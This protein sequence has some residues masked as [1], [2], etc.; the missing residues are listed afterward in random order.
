MTTDEIID[1]KNLIIGK[2][3]VNGETIYGCNLNTG[4]YIVGVGCI[5]YDHEM[6]VCM[7]AN[8]YNKQVKINHLNQWMNTNLGYFEDFGGKVEDK[9]VNMHIIDLA[10]GEL[11]EESAM[12]FNLHYEDLVNCNTVL[13]DVPGYKDTIRKYLCFI[14]HVDLKDHCAIKD[15]FNKNVQTMLSGRFSCQKQFLEI[16]NIK[17]FMVSDLERLIAAKKA[18][19]GFYGKPDYV[20]FAND[21]CGSPSYISSRIVN[22]VEMFKK[23][24]Q[25]THKPTYFTYHI[26]GL[27]HIVSEE[28]KIETAKQEQD[29]KLRLY[30]QKYFVSRL[31]STKPGVK[32]YIGGDIP[33]MYYNEINSPPTC[34][35]T[36]P[37]LIIYTDNPCF[38]LVDNIDMFYGGNDKTD[39]TLKKLFQTTSKST[40][41]Q[42]V[43][44]QLNSRIYFSYTKNSTYNR[45]F[46]GNI[47]AIDDT[48]ITFNN[49]IY[50]Q[51]LAVDSCNSI[52]IAAMHNLVTILDTTKV[53]FDYFDDDIIATARHWNKSGLERFNK[54]QTEANKKTQDTP[55]SKYKIDEILKK[56][57]TISQL[58]I[59]GKYYLF[60]QIN[61]LICAKENTNNK[62]Y[63]NFKTIIDNYSV[64][65]NR[66]FSRCSPPFEFDCSN[67]NATKSIFEFKTND[68]FIHNNLVFMSDSMTNLPT[69]YLNP[70]LYDCFKIDMHENCGFVPFY[71]FG[72]K[73]EFYKVAYETIIKPETK[74]QVTN[75]EYQ[76]IQVFKLSNDLVK[77]TGKKYF[78]RFITITPLPAPVQA[79]ELEQGGGSA[80]IKKT[81]RKPSDP[82]SFF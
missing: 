75:V 2:H 25:I 80:K 72:D 34:V 62:N 10:L 66:T 43:F 31:D 44:F 30:L 71:L 55:T 58:Q 37:R 32:M 9:H 53:V 74:F 24:I 45:V 21:M 38:A 56:N 82:N 5:L 19:K 42:G 16:N 27:Q 78:R 14:I 63:K 13:I 29:S 64:K 60:E 59:K 77:D 46:I 81:P 65:Q 76:A 35:I 17:F 15:M 47:K 22:I 68:T 28:Y 67:N 1:V 70:G 40:F 7:L 23:D 49:I 39:S 11:F 20:Y 54:L 57:T 4:N 33:M 69:F 12:V 48:I 51:T 79:L 26:N 73:F 3:N 36:S 18:I 6:K 52:A 50:K 8:E 61:A 41:S